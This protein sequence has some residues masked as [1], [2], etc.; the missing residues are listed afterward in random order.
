MSKEAIPANSSER[1]FLSELAARAAD[2]KELSKQMHEESKE[3]KELMKQRIEELMKQKIEDIK[4]IEKQKYEIERLKNE[5]K[6]QREQHQSELQRLKDKHDVELGGIGKQSDISE[7]IN[8]DLDSNE[9]IK[10]PAIASGLA[11]VQTSSSFAPDHDV[12]RIRLGFSD[13]RVG[14]GCWCAATNDTNQYVQVS[15]TVSRTWVSISTQGR[16]NCDQWVKSYFISYTDNGLDWIMAE[17]GKVFTGNNDKAT[18]VSYD[19][20]KP[21]V[22][23]SVRIHI[24][25]WQIHISMRM[26]LYYKDMKKGY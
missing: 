5:I 9:T 18:V 19:F 3:S 11:L 22:A 10:V 15:S 21:F 1:N 16:H 4:E 13:F 14:S 24:A 8:T 20:A 12:S 2:F 23:K 25:T 6:Q 17:D 26:E 7:A